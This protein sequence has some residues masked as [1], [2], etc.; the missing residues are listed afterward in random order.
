MNTLVTSASFLYP[1]VPTAAAK[2]Y[3]ETLVGLEFNELEGKSTLEPG[4]VVYT[5]TGGSV[6]DQN[7]LEQLRDGIRQEAQRLGYP[8]ENSDFGK[9][10]AE[11]SQWLHENLVIRPSEACRS[12]VWAFFGLYLVPEIARWRF[13]GNTGTSS[14]ERFLGSQR[15]LR[16]VLGRLWWRGEYLH[17][18][19]GLGLYTGLLDELDDE[20]RVL[21]TNDSYGL[22]KLLGEDELVGI[23]E[24]PSL[25][26][27]RA[28]CRATARALVISHAR[29]ST[30]KRSYL[31]REAMKKI[32]R[33]GGIMAFEA[34]D[35]RTLLGVLLGVFDECARAIEEM[36][37]G[38]Q[39]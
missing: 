36:E 8:D 23:T 26:G 21:L 22:L 31:L 1:Q 38:A 13:P 6:I 17:Q 3:A 2:K 27:N 19:L 24:R 32:Y 4:G 10:D 18:E 5:P 28:F 37:R 12:G 34:L 9:F 35:E 30:G 20:S 39:A 15:G 11:M 33:L 29:S 7:S 14:A 25:S 16:N